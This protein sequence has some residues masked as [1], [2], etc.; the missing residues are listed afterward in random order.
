MKAVFCLP[1][2]LAAGAWADENADRAAIERVIAAVNSVPAPD[3]LFTADTDAADALKRIWRDNPPV[4]RFPSRNGER[5]PL[6]TP[7]VT[8]SHEPWGEATIGVT[9]PP[10]EIVNPRIEVRSIRFLTADVALADAACVYRTASGTRARPLLFVMRK[11][12]DAWKIA[13]LR[14]L[15]QP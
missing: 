2:L 5:A 14:L 8:I 11:E 6:G 13:S 9:M 4:Y 1:L 12:G 3:A 10:G 7:T 15:A